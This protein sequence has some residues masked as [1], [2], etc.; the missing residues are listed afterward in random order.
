VAFPSFLS[1]FLWEGYHAFGVD[2]LRGTLSPPL[3]GGNGL[4]RPLGPA[5]AETG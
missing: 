5:L 1:M 2:T 4:Q 3:M